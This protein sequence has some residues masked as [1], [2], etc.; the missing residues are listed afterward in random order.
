MDK[1]LKAMKELEA[2]TVSIDDVLNEYD[3][4]IAKIEEIHFLQLQIETKMQNDDLLK[5]DYDKWCDEKLCLIGWL[6]RLGSFI[7]DYKKKHNIVSLDSKANLQNL[8]HFLT[9]YNSIR[10]QVIDQNITK[11]IENQIND[12]FHSIFETDEVLIN[13][14]VYK[15]EDIIPYFEENKKLDSVSSM[16]NFQS[17]FLVGLHTNMYVDSDFL[18]ASCG[19]YIGLPRKVVALKVSNDNGDFIVHNM[20]ELNSSL[21]C[22]GKVIGVQGSCN[23]VLEGWYKFE[24]IILC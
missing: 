5:S 14:V 8:V 18:M 19:Y 13:N 11:K 10:K 1:L 12:L 17:Q 16:I 3:K 20:E 22:N 23:D 2:L 7:T 24:D 6:L 15:L 9:K 4:V 21:A